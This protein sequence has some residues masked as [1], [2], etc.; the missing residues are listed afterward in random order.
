MQ[1]D[2]KRHS[3]L[4]F[5]LCCLRFSG[6]IRVYIS[7]NV[8]SV[9]SQCVCVCFREREMG[10]NPLIS[11]R[12]SQRH[13]SA[14]FGH[15]SRDGRGAKA[16]PFHSC[17]ASTVGLKQTGSAYKD[18]GVTRIHWT[19]RQVLRFALFINLS[20]SLHTGIVTSCWGME[21]VLG[22]MEGGVVIQEEMCNAFN[23]S[24]QKHCFLSSFLQCDT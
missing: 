3:R 16:A 20:V 10:D 24:E 13:A 6:S 5:S 2:D 22:E 12:R 18:K 8:M 9:I 15:R 21:G 11:I 4:C 19:L 7:V 17:G 23:L 1:L 14:D